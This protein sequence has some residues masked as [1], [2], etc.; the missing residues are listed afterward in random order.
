MESYYNAPH[1]DLSSRVLL[2]LMAFEILLDIPENQQR[3]HFKQ[4]I[5]RLCRTR[6]DRKRA[7]KSER[8]GGKTATERGTLK[9]IWADRFYTLRNHLIHG[10]EVAD[11]EYMFRNAQHHLAASPVVFI[12]AVRALIDNEHV[13]RGERRA[14]KT[15]LRWSKWEDLND[16][17]GTNYRGFTLELDWHTIVLEELGLGRKKRS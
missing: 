17:P 7:Y 15:M 3:M 13:S 11:R 8:P 16:A 5:G 6:G 14:F 10:N 12:A 4:A 2:Q 1:V 9:E